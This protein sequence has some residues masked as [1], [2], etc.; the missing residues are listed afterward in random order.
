M[1]LA[2]AFNNSDK[3]MQ[4]V[5]ASHR[6]DLTVSLTHTRFNSDLIQTELT[7]SLV[8]SNKKRHLIHGKLGWGFYSLITTYIFWVQSIFYFTPCPSCFRQCWVWIK[9]VWILHFFPCTYIYIFQRDN[10]ANRFII[11]NPIHLI[12]FNI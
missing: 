7:A 3:A 2:L 9:P 10:T 1:F 5:F 11:Y 6:P 8:K 12:N 4:H